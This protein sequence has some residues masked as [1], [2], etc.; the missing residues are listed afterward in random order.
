MYDDFALGQI[1]S[2]NN[3]FQQMGIS[4]PICRYNKIKEK[5]GHPGKS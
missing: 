2:Q 4:F 5:L 1:I 3:K